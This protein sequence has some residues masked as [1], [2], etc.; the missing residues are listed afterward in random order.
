MCI[1]LPEAVGNQLQIGN[2]NPDLIDLPRRYGFSV[3]SPAMSGGMVDRDE[4]RK[5]IAEARD[6]KAM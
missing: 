2:W 6:M 3:R 1:I 5:V 4:L